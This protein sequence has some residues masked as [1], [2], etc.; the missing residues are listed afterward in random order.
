MS[1][2]NIHIVTDKR[3]ESHFLDVARY[4]YRNDP[5]WVCPLDM[6]IR[7]IFDPKKSAKVTGNGIAQRWYLTDNQG[8]YIG[9]IAAFINNK[10]AR[11]EKFKIGGIGFFECINDQSIANTLF[12]IAKDWL[13]KQNAQVIDGPVN[14]GENDR[15]WG[16]LVEGF[17]HPGYGM[18]YNPPYYQ[19]LF[20]TYGF[21]MFFEQ[22]SKHLDIT[23][24]LPERFQKISEWIM[25]KGGFHF[26]SFDMKKIAKYSEDFR[27][28]Y[29]DAWQFHENFQEMTQEALNTLINELKPIIIPDMICFAYEQNEP[30]GF[31]LCLPDLNQIFKPL[32]GKFG[33]LEAV[34]FLW[35]KRNGFEWY[36]K[37]GQL[38]RGRVVIMG[39]RPKYQRYG[40]ESGLIMHP[41]PKVRALGFKEIELSWVGDF[42]PKMQKLHE[43]TG[44]TF[45]KKHHTYRIAIDPNVTISR[46]VIIP[47][48]TRDQLT[49]TQ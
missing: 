2:C 24:E 12:D 6:E 8:N 44:A 45:G 23:K 30:A 43:N 32:K 4:L 49:D 14:F 31:V 22:F 21:Q 39:I 5:V 11:G 41:M 36:R 42:N 47:T 13:L 29:N 37:N 9:R 10:K 18:P 3:T 25:R 46:S 1:N 16:L 15:Y 7:N 28:I 35:R 33:I 48:D 20:E 40:L 27:T 19:K 38:T 17:T 26:E 34:K